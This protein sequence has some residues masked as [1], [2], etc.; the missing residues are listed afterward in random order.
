GHSQWCSLAWKTLRRRA[1]H[2]TRSYR[3]GT[4]MAYPG[5]PNLAASR[6]RPGSTSTERRCTKRLCPDEAEA[7]WPVE[8]ARVPGGY[9]GPGHV[10]PCGDIRSAETDEPCVYRGTACPRSANRLGSVRL[11]LLVDAV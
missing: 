11:L 5:S 8:L 6:W 4:P 2:A 3:P 1:S 9:T 10:V 7:A